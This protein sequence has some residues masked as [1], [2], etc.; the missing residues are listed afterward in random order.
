ME[1]QVTVVQ[2][3]NVRTLGYAVTDYIKLG[4]EI[5]GPPF[6]LNNSPSQ[7]VIKTNRAAPTEPVEYQ[8]V[9]GNSAALQ[10]EILG[11]L[12]DGWKLHSNLIVFESL[13]SQA[14][15]MGPVPVYGADGAAN[16]D[17]LIARLQLAEATGTANTVAIDNLTTTVSS[18]TSR[19]NTYDGQMLSKANLVNG[20]VPYSELPEFPVG[21]KVSVANAAARLALGNHTDLTIAYQQDTA[22]AWALNPN[23]DASV[24][25]NWSKLGNAQATGVVTFNGRAGNIAPQANDYTTAQIAETP[26]KRFV[27]TAQINQWNSAPNPGL[28]DTKI[29]EQK[30]IDD[31]LYETKAHATQTF[32]LKTDIPAAPNLSVLVPKT[33]INKANGVAPLDVNKRVPTANLPSYLPQK[34]RTWVARSSERTHGMWYTNDSGNEMELFLSSNNAV[35]GSYFNVQMRPNASGSTIS[36]ISNSSASG[37]GLPSTRAFSNVTVP[38]GWQY[39]VN[40]SNIA[41]RSITTWHELS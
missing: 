11:M 29:A 39:S 10:A 9:T 31:A 28:I 14:M 34:A 30:V 19:L 13:P 16:V 20:K 15:L 12:L 41:T 7:I 32:A 38:A 17:D 36:F 37:A 35:D 22:D 21:R 26:E 2:R 23:D 18:Q 8:L 25:G 6:I 4:W 24:A 33:D 1:Q 40:T 27:S 5:Y 3:D